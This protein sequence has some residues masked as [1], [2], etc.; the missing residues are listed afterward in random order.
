M[1]PLHLGHFTDV[2]FFARANENE[3]RAEA[4]SCAAPKE[5]FHGRGHSKR[6]PTLRARPKR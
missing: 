3:T 1:F 5:N 2:M 6:Q 4:K